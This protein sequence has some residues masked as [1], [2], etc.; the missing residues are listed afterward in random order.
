MALRDFMLKYFKIKCFH[1]TIC[2]RK[3][4]VEKTVKN[5]T[6]VITLQ[7]ETVEKYKI[8][9]YHDLYFIMLLLADMCEN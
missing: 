3:D 4:A 9:D 6:K 1:S 7:P 2:N 5:R 8:K